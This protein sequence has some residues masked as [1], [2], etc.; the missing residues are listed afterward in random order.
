MIRA[1]TLILSLQLAGE[2]LAAGLALP[3]PGPVLGM[4][5][6]LAV[7]AWQGGPTEAQEGVAKGFLDNLG[8]LFVP[9]GVGVML[10]LPTVAAE[11]RA[12]MAT[13]LLGTVITIA[14]TALAFRWL[15]R[16]TGSDE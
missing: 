15:S 9:A 4:A 6:L 1:L 16:L 14:V 8:L 11:W 5:G 7:F 3:V 2:A 12:I 10:H 13:V